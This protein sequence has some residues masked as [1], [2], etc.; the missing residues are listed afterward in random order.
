MIFD[1]TTTGK[2]ITSGG[3]RFY[4][5]TFN[6]DGGSWTVQDALDVDND[7]TLIKGTVSGNVT[8]TSPTTDLDAET[9]IGETE[10]VEPA[11]EN[12]PEVP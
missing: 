6:G 2:T 8:F 10:P 3:S 1:S 4:N 5:L 7:L 9:G 11:M 12:I